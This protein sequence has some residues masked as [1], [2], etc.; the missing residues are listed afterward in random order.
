MGISFFIY[1]HI[2]R[3]QLGRKTGAGCI[4]ETQWNR[5]LPEKLT[6]PQLVKKFP[7]FHGSREVYYRIHN[8]PPQLCLP[9]APQSRCTRNFDAVSRSR[10]EMLLPPV[11]CDRQANPK[12]RHDK[13]YHYQ[14]FIRIQHCKILQLTA[15]DCSHFTHSRGCHIGIDLTGYK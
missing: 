2:S 8:R 4:S 3:T 9:T 13:S 7:A 10:H 12:S 5:V 1:V 14:V 6:A 15:L 11:N